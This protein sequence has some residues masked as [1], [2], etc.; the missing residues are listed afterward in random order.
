VPYAVSLPTRSPLLPNVPTFSELGFPQLEAQP[1][2]GMWVTPDVP[3]STQTRLREAALKIMSQPAAIERLKEAGLDPAQ[4]R[5][6]DELAKSLNTDYER[7]GTVL[8]SINFKPE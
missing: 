4:A 2:F 3:V 1:W 8:K 5:S 6:P 7:I